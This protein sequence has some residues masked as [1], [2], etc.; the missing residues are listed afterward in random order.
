MTCMVL[1]RI[2]IVEKKNTQVVEIRVDRWVK[3]G[4]KKVKPGTIWNYEFG[5]YYKKKK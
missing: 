1:G 5:I 4:V 2:I 3:R